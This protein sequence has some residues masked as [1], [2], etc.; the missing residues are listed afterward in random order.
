MGVRLTAILAT[1]VLLVAPGNASV[2]PAR[3][4]LMTAFQLPAS[5]IDRLDRGEVVSRTLDVKNRREIATLGIVRIK[6]S[7]S[8]YVERLADIA[9]FKRT[10][11]VLQIGTFST[12]PRLADV[13]ALTVD[14]ADLKR[15]RECRVENCDVRLSADAIESVRREIDWRAADGSRQAS[16]LVSQLLV[17]YVGRYRQSGT[18]AAMEYADRSPRLNVGQEFASLLEADNLYDAFQQRLRRHMHDT[19]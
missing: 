18:T 11:G 5:E 7:P 3:S 1:T 4:V 8:K 6:T 17:E 13:A 2:D 15:L 10:A 9:T 12:P 14:D 19:I 16:R